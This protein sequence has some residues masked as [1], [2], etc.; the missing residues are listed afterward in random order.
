MLE[1]LGLKMLIIEDEAATAR[2]VSCRKPVDRAQ[3]RFGNQCNSKAPL[4]IERIETLKIAAP[5]APP[6]PVSRA[7]LRVIQGKR[8]GGQ[9]ARRYG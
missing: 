5:Q 7:H 3:Q 8:K 1:T 6:V 4:K 2:T 9:N